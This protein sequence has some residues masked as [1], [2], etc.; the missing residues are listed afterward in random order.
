MY[1]VVLILKEAF[2]SSKR[3]VLSNAE[4]DCPADVNL[5]LG[6]ALTRVFRCDF[7]TS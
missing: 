7:T 1:L 4:C 3:E 5:S 2:V 6:T